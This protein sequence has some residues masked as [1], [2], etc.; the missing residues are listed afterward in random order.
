MTA[1]VCYD[2]LCQAVEFSCLRIN[3]GLDRV[4]KMN[5]TTRHA[6]LGRVGVLLL[7]VLLLAPV[8]LAQPFAPRISGGQDAEPGEWPWHV[9]LVR[10]GQ[11]PFD[12]YFCAGSLID[13]NWVLTAAHC[14]DSYTTIN[15]LD[16]IAGIHNLHTPEPNHRRVALEKIIVHEAYGMVWLE[17]NEND[18]ALLRLAEPID[19][20]PGDGETLPIATIEP[21]GTNV[22][23]IVDQLMP[24]IGWGETPNSPGAPSEVLQEAQVPIIPNEVCLSRF[25]SNLYGPMVITDNT[26]CLSSPEGNNGTCVGDS[27]G[28]MPYYDETEGRWRLAGVTAFGTGCSSN[29]EPPQTSGLVRVSR[30]AHWIR[31]RSQLLPPP[32]NLINL[33]AVVSEPSGSSIVNGD[34]EMGQIGWRSSY[35]IRQGG[36]AHGGEWAAHFAPGGTSTLVFSQEVWVP[37]DRPVLNYYYWINVAQNEPWA[38]DANVVRV[39]IDGVMVAEH[40][41]CGETDTGGWVAYSIDLSESKNQP[42]MLVFT[43]MT[44]DICGSFTGML[45]IDDIAFTATALGDTPQPPRRHAVNTMDLRG[46]RICSR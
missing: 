1:T 44:M 46:S 40:Q 22:N 36:I 15:D 19:E 31:S 35:I 43:S 4:N 5:V 25:D 29:P 7:L 11:T 14:V 41:L 18:L 8:V 3:A 39:L 9:A 34:F 32:T 30:Y 42:A 23:L 27:G 33:P 13:R 26:I 16:V 20:R 21:A 37:T 28:S 17:R 38:C 10:K 45:F 2:E 6:A 24:I 12:G